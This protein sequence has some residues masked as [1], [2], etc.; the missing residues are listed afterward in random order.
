MHPAALRGVAVTA[1]IAALAAPA[2]PQTLPSAPPAV[3]APGTP[4]GWTRFTLP[5]AVIVLV[6]ERP[7]IPIVIVRVAVDA[8]AVLDPPDQA[9]V[10]N[11]TALLLTRGSTTRTALEADRAIEFVGGS[12]EGEG[13]RDASGLTLSVLRKDLSL[14]LDLLADALR[15]PVFP[16]AEF[17]RKREEVRASVRRSE[18]DPGAVAGR[19]FR[20]LVFPGHPYGR[21]VS[22][23]EASLAGTMRAHVVA[24]H[25]AAY[26][27]ERT[28]VAVAGDVTA[29]EVR[30][31]LGARL[32]DWVA[33]GAAPSPPWPVALGAPPRTD[34][35]QRTLTQ[36]SIILGQATVTRRHPDFYPLLVASQVLGGGSSSRLYTRIREERGLAYSVYAQYATAR[37][38]GLFLVELQCENARVRE[39]LAVVREELVRLR[40]ERVPEE[41]LAR[42]RSYLVGSF[43]LGMATAADVSDLLLAIERFNLG[44]D[45]PVAFRRA[46]SAVTA[47]DVLRAV[48]THW[49]PDAMSLA[50][51]GNLREAGLGGP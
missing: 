40:R 50:L 12:L 14:G 34:T 41:E 45:Y 38:A 19:A 20:R 22:G 42:A 26:R 4:A 2:R 10:A 47:E 28:I 25:Q 43:P 24:F 16:D 15:R 13:G 6:A 31:E 27:P 23:T 7:G 48:R 32:G 21:P 9:G 30:A 17:E 8:G 18:E 46:V 5:N 36:A 11:L 51:V 44:L 33:T 35:V 49:D 29:A 1:T 3:P 39:A 37:L